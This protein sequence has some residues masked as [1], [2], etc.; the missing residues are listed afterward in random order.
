[1]EEPTVVG[2]SSPEVKPVGKFG[3]KLKREREMRGISLD[4]IAEA[5]KIGKRSLRALEEDRFD[6]L[7][8]GIFNKGFVRAYARCVGI[9]EEQ[10]VADYLL[11]LGE[12]Q[13][14][15]DPVQMQQ[16]AQQVQAQ[17]TQM[18]RDQNTVILWLAVLLVLAVGAVGWYGW[19]TYEKQKT[20]HEVPLQQPKVVQQEA[21]PAQ[22]QV[23]VATPTDANGTTA[24]GTQLTT[25]TTQPTTSPVTTPQTVAPGNASNASP[26]TGVT[27]EAPDN[28]PVNLTLR[29]LGRTWI[30]VTVDGGR[31]ETMTLDPNDPKMKSRSFHGNEKVVLL[32]GNPAG[33]EATFNGKKLD[34][35][36]A[37][38]QRRQV[39]FT[40]K[41]MQ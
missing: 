38:G 14:V 37:E 22:T 5:T 13:K 31:T 18:E 29:A 4:E 17:R 32:T 41:G 15:A 24:M 12:Q 35:L 40:P 19:H 6:Q 20:E 34:P 25:A 36:G 3:D 7:P 21:P 33:L 8:G 30:S 11:S 1:V 2:G 16:I 23:P 10:A 28:A 26:A 27:G 9:D 39:T